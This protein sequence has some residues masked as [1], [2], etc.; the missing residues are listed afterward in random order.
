[1]PKDFELKITPKS[2]KYL[3]KMPEL[4]R[5]GAYKGLKRAMLDIEAY[6]VSHFTD[7][8]LHVRSGMLRNS[9][10]SKV[11]KKDKDTLI[12]VLGANTPYATIHELG[13]TIS[14]SNLFGKGISAQIQIPQREYLSPAID[15]NLKS[16]SQAVSSAIIKEVERG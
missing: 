16:A 7:N 14:H 11:L 9:I 12:G 8:G 15:K 1:M 4:A 10:N 13:G 3:T 6:S 5:E 2:E